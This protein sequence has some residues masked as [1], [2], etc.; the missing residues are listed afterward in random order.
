M[1]ERTV[2][3]TG[4]APFALHP[5]LA[6]DTIELVR[7]KCCRI[8]LMND[9]TYPWLILV[10]QRPGLRDF[11]DLAGVDMMATVAE[12]DTASRALQ[13]LFDPVKINVAALGNMV[14][15]LH[16]HVIARRTDDAAWPKP[17]WGVTPARAYGAAALVARVVA[18][19][20]A[21]T[22]AAA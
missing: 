13:A 8:L 2:Q 9:A 16:I 5:Q 11:H 6:V 18:L 15:Q 4:E 12:I 20:A 3:V 17:V 14:P 7:G 10:P 1:R 19:R 21:L 22:A